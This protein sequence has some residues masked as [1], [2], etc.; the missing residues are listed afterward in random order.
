MA[1]K[2][3]GKKPVKKAPKAL[4]KVVK[5]VVPKEI[6]E[7]PLKSPFN[8]KE[9]EVFKEKLL[10]FK[11]DLLNQIQDMSADTLMK[12]QKDLSGDISGYSLHMADVASDNYDREFNLGLV[13]DERGVLLD[14]EE[15]LK[16]VEDGSYGLCRMCR[17]G[18]SKIRLA[19]IPYT[20]YCKKCQE[21]IEKNQPA[22]E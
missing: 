1:N 7:K 16:R 21:Q 15:A 19:A 10:N 14:A 13:S 17:K 9:I 5:I 4:E 20:K 2:S 22:K 18:I 8:K 11:E 6:K 12:S 3:K